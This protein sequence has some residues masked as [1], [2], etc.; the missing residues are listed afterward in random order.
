MAATMF[1]CFNPPT[2]GLPGRSGPGRGALVRRGV[3]RARSPRAFA[4]AGVRRETTPCRRADAIEHAVVPQ[5]DPMKPAAPDSRRL[6]L[7]EKFRCGVLDQPAIIGFAI[8]RLPLRNGERVEVLGRNDAGGEKPARRS[9]ERAGSGIV[10]VAPVGGVRRLNGEARRL[11]PRRPAAAPDVPPGWGG[12]PVR[13]TRL[14]EW[15]NGRT[16]ITVTIV[17]QFASG[18]SRARRKKGQNPNK[19]QPFAATRRDFAAAQRFT[20]T[21]SASTGRRSSSGCR[22]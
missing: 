3:K 21:L 8:D 6:V 13:P 15:A 7:G 10:R 20:A 22:R 5:H 19:C 16:S 11:T 17:I 14:G 4:A 1:G 18:E 12:R 2:A 9:K